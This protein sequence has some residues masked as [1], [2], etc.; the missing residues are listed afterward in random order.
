MNIVTG[1]GG[2]IGFHIAKKLLE[3]GDNVIGI[4]NLDPYY[5]VQ[6]KLD[7]LNELKKYTKFKLLKKDFAE[8]KK[9]EIKDADVIFHE[10]ARAG[11]R[12][13]IKD[14]VFYNN[15]NVSSTVKLLKL[16][17]DSNIKKFIFASSSSV[18]GDITN[19]PTKENTP[20]NPKNPYGVSKLAGEKYCNSFYNCYG[21][22]CI[23]LRYFTVYGPWG[24]PDMLIFKVLDSCYNGSPFTRFQKNGKPVEFKRD[25][26]FIED[27]VNANILAAKS[28]IKND[29]FNIG[30]SKEVSIEKIITLI[31]DFTGREPKTKDSEPNPADVF[32]TC[33]DISKAKKELGYT[34]KTFTETGIKKT[35]EWY[36]SYKKLK[37]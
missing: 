8:L 30:S 24:R 3:N 18:Y 20:T 25:F 4:D 14:P 16:A 37:N 10:A 28:K 19:F 21:L 34:P 33:A 12:A 22:S 5:D 6:L 36:K 1:A 29:Y 31:K 35:V 23:S 2:F 32:R 11:V 26:T 27:V 17:A 13:S 9:N 7:R 15:V